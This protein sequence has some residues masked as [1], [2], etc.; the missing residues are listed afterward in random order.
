MP[1]GQEALA[2]T[3]L[4]HG[5][6]KH[7]WQR[8]ESEMTDASYEGVVRGAGGARWTR[9]VTRRPHPRPAVLALPDY[10]T[11]PSGEGP[12]VFRVQSNESAFPPA[13]AVARAIAEAGAAGNRYPAFGGVDVVDALADSLGVEAAAL[14]VGDGA[15]SLLQ[16]VLLTY[17][18]PGDR[19]VYGWRSYE[20][21]PIAVAIAGGEAVT[22]PN[23]P[24]HALDL[25]GTAA[26]VA[27]GARAVIVCNPN[28]PT[29]TAFGRDELERFLACVPADVLV[30]H[31]EAYA[32][33]VDA[34]RLTP[35][36]ATVLLAQHPNLV[37][38]RTFS[39]VHSLAGLRVGY[40]V[41]DPEVARAVRR[42][43]PPFPVSA[44]AA[45]A[46]I[47]ALGASEHRDLVVETVARERELVAA[48]LVDA[49]LA[50]VPSHTN[51]LWVP[52]ADS[53][54][55]AARLRAAGIAIRPFPEGVRISVGEPGLAAALRTVLGV[56]NSRPEGA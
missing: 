48:A 35:F 5:G 37:V 30:V 14:A 29:G 36:D 11:A 45:A 3:R 20:A 21:Y 7:E 25:D 4:Q 18:R 13:P 17:V 2:T 6:L 55:F 41:A 49:G 23:T 15:L 42:V 8:R 43:V 9:R 10:S 34:A 24:E 31:D 52:M 12:V 1:P 47:A 56:L 53:T 33:F 19:V 50:P 32:D 40:L 44:V 38:L 26:A 28:N 51:F 46:A 16:H 27:E 39:K 22:V 54:A